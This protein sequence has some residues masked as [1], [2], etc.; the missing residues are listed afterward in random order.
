MGLTAIIGTVTMTDIA[1]AIRER[2]GTEALI[3]GKNF[4]SAIRSIKPKLQVLDAQYN[5]VYKPDDGYE[6]FSKVIVTSGDAPDGES[7]RF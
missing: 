6:G 3:Q 5:G 7:M 1:N 4:A 2:T